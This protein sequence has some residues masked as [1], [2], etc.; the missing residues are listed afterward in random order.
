MLFLGT[1][2]GVN[3]KRKSCEWQHSSAVK[4]VEVTE[5]AISQVI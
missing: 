3:N 2:G 5:R 1:S 4:S